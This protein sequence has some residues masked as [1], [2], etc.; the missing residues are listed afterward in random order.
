MLFVFVPQLCL[1]FRV[2]GLEARQWFMYLLISIFLML[3]QRAQFLSQ[4]DLDC[5]CLDFYT[6]KG[7]VIETNSWRH[8]EK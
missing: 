7:V 5:L 2:Q 1:H 6:F 3:A 4:T 8:C